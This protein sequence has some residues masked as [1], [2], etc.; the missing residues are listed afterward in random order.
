MTLQL[1]GA[2]ILIVIK[3]VTTNYSKIL[4]RRKYIMTKADIMQQVKNLIAAPSC[5]AGLKEKAE[6]YLMV[7]NPETATALVN[8]LK[9]D[10]Q[11]IDEVLPFFGSEDAKKIFGA[12]I[13]EQLLQ[14][15]KEVK[16]NGGDTCFCEACT[17][18][19][20]ILDHQEL[21]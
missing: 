17:A 16:A 9:A 15:A 11:S 5:Y 10:V 13:A 4:Q 14:K 6:A 2:T 7:Q 18:G 19:K 21:L 1:S 8:E 12:E 20:V 3:V